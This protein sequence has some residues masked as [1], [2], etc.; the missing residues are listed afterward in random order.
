MH[1]FTNRLPR[2]KVS[3][4][5]ITLDDCFFITMTTRLRKEREK[6]RD[7]GWQRFNL[8]ATVC[9]ANSLNPCSQ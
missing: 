9:H 8:I 2:L 4:L 1:Q 6:E 5:T 3:L 7:M